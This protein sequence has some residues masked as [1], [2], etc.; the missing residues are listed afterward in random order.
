LRN[1]VHVIE[2]LH[3]LSFDT[4][5]EL[6]NDLDS[7]PSYGYHSDNAGDD[8]DTEDC[9]ERPGHRVFQERKVEN[10]VT[11]VTRKH[12]IRQTNNRQLRLTAMCD[13]VTCRHSKE[14]NSERQLIQIEEM[15]KERML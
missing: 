4:I 14:T 8:T 1:S 11:P 7:D 5:P 15:F 9:E 10:G 13:C 2:R 12:S 6:A 3:S